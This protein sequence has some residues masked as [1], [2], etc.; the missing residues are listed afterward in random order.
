MIEL[1]QRW[2]Y[3]TTTSGQTRIVLKITLPRR[4]I[5]SELSAKPLN[6]SLDTFFNLRLRVVIEQPARL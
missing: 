6:E 3:P 1:V 2:Q 4:D 5:S